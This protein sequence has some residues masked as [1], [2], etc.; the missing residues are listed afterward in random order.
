MNRTLLLILC[1]F[2]LLNILALTSWE[3]AEPVRTPTPTAATDAENGAGSVEQDLVEVMRLSLED[4]RAQRDQLADRLQATQ[5]NLAETQSTLAEREQNLAGLQQEKAQLDSALD[6][7]RASA[8]QLA[9]QVEAARRDASMSQERLAQL[10]RDLE[11]REAEAVRQR[12]QLQKLEQAQTEARERI[13]NLNVAVRVAEQEKVLLR[14]TAE[15]FRQQAEAER[16]ERIKVQEATT[17]L[18][19]GVGQLAER[20]ADLS[21]EIRDN[22]PINANVLFSDFMANR[23]QTAFA[24]RREALLGPLTVP[25]TET[26]TLFVTD[27]DNTYAMLHV[28]D[29]PF[30]LHTPQDW[31]RVDVAFSKGTYRTGAASVGFLEL[32]PRVVAI[33]VDP[34]QV[35]ALGVKV[36]TLASDPFRFPD[37]LLISRGGAGYGEVPFKLDPG[38]PNY[39]RMDNRLVRRLFG[40]FSPSR[41]DLVLSKSGELLGIMVNGDHC[42]IVSRLALA[43]S[44][45]TGDTSAQRTSALF[46]DLAARVRRLPARLQ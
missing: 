16:V 39:V 18:A 41:G 32:D 35:A 19:A 15:T 28:D 37:A 12:E 31:M 22:R 17:E 2:L 30:L 11:Q 29:S 6:Q 13:E 36:Y 43:G 34:A 33:P 26:R 4:E 14:E 5:S 42:V 25:P 10:Q 27:G 46:S 23:V 45:A 44:F 21:R 8:A 1:D 7:T 38:N 20:S 3:K 40:D 9:Q 24:A